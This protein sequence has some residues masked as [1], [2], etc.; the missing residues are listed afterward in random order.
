MTEFDGTRELLYLFIVLQVQPHT[1][2]PLYSDPVLLSHLQ[3]FPTQSL[4]AIKLTVT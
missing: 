4:A 2:C 3:L 1:L